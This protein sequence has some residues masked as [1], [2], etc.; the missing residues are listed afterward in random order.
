MAR[1]KT[2]GNIDLMT[3]QGLIDAREGV[4]SQELSQIIFGD[5]TR[6]HVTSVNHCCMMGI[7]THQLDIVKRRANMSIYVLWYPARFAGEAVTE[8]EKCAKAMGV[9]TVRQLGEIYHET[10]C[11]GRSGIAK[12]DTYLG[13]MVEDGT[14]EKLPPVGRETQKYRWINYE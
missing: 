10:K 2:P 7:R 3:L 4:T 11:V 6:D 14:I 8:I 9:F 5:A 1:N 13:L 12:L